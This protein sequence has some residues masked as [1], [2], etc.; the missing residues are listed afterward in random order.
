MC[1]EE[2]DGAQLERDLLNN[3]FKHLEAELEAEKSA[4]TERSREVRGLEVSP[5][6]WS[7]SQR[8][9]QGARLPLVE[10]GST[11]QDWTRPIPDTR[12]VTCKGGN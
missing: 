3:R 11:L 7:C 4:H 6:H 2:R 1:C 9:N 10:A 12:N 5:R 8:V